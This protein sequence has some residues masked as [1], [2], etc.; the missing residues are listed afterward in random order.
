MTPTLVSRADGRG[1]GIC[2]RGAGCTC[3]ASSS[4]G[5]GIRVN[6][7]TCVGGEGGATHTQVYSHP[8][9]LR[10]IGKLFF[11]LK[12]E[13]IGAALPQKARPSRSAKHPEGSAEAIAAAAAAAA[14]PATKREQE[15]QQQAD[16]IIAQK[17]ARIEHLTK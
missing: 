17:E 12:F 6:G 14:E 4:E 3:V 15:Q 8:A 2:S 9:L 11:F 5:T 16:Q 1:V 10:K 7:H 13:F